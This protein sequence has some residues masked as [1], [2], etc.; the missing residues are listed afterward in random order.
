MVDGKSG[1][2]LR[3]TACRC[4]APIVAP[5][6]FLGSFRRRRFRDQLQRFVDVDFARH[7]PKAGPRDV[8]VN[9]KAVPIDTSENIAKGIVGEAEQEVML[10]ADLPLGS[11]RY[12]EA[13]RREW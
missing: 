6:S 2:I 11:S 10:S 4:R 8:V 1:T 9:L 12:W 7:F 5:A 3:D 13:L